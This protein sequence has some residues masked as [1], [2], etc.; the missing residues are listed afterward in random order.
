MNAN[1]DTTSTLPTTAQLKAKLYGLTFKNAD[2]L[3]RALNGGRPVGF[4]PLVKFG[5][6]QTGGRPM[7]HAYGDY[8]LATFNATNIAEAIDGYCDRSRKAREY[9]Q[10][11][12][13]VPPPPQT[14]ATGIT[15]E[16]QIQEAYRQQEAEEDTQ[17]DETPAHEYPSGSLEAQIVAIVRAEASRTRASV[18]P[19]TVARIT[20][21]LID[22]AIAEAMLPR[23]THINVTT[24][25][26]SGQ[27]RTA[28]LGVQHV[29]FPKLLALCGMRIGNGRRAN[30]WLP[31]PAGSGKTTAAENVA[32]ALGMGYG[33]TGALMDETKVFGYMDANGNYIATEFFK[34]Y[35]QGG[36]F[37][38]D[39]A[40]GSDPMIS[41]MINAA[42]DG[43]R[44]AFPHG[45]FNRHPDFI[46]IA[47][48]NTFG[49][50][51][52]AKYV[53][54]NRLDAAT[55][56]RFIKLEWNYDNALERH[57]I[58]DTL[59]YDRMMHYRGRVNTCGYDMVISTR[60]GIHHA[61]LR[62]M[63]DM[64]T[65]K[66]A[67]VIAYRDGMTDDQWSQVNR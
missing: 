22:A 10:T 42:I 18:D 7:V 33:Y 34:R 5:K 9:V 31:G 37:L 29:L 54:R 46:F 27:A 60:N 56:N 20:K 67:E 38:W 30:V 32:R 44:A 8:I 3:A 13:N 25:D 49:Y 36:V 14:S 51:A 12:K 58:G 50:G 55:L 17:A 23:V 64:F 35:T 41:V 40:D 16:A 47:A 53:G 43:T 19:A 24:T 11:V 59:A 48:A 61:T 2:A 52:D 57:I 39:E 45:M 21:G 62:G 65:A 4:N 63:G 66:E 1:A 26:A 15:D 28:E 6:A